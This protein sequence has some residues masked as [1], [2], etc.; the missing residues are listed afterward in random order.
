VSTAQVRDELAWMANRF[1][2]DP[3][4]HR[5]LAE[6]APRTPGCNLRLVYRVLAHSAESSVPGRRA[7]SSDIRGS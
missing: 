3:A 6:V 5:S 4:L 2:L 7:V 1:Q